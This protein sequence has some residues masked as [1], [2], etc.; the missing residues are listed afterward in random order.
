M[1]SSLFNP[2]GADHLWLLVPQGVEFQR[3]KQGLLRRSPQTALEINLQK[4]PAGGAAVMEALPQLATQWQHSPQGIIVM[5]V[6]GSLCPELSIGESVFLSQV[7]TVGSL[8]YQKTDPDLT[9]QLAARLQAKTSQ[10]FR[11]NCI[12]ASTPSVIATMIAKQQLAQQTQ[13][14]VVDMENAAILDFAKTQNIPTAILRVVSDSMTGD[15]PDLSQAVDAQGNLNPWA[16]TQ[17]FLKQPI[18]AG[19]LIRGSLKACHQ[20]ERLATCL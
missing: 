5:G 11:T 9:Q 8:T 14:Q 10:A 2:I 15:L 1:S 16:L 13:A 3:V 6:C 18:A 20:L 12:G 17:A 7:Q 4:I 19:R